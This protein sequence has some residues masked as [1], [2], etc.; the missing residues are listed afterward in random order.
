MPL[1]LQNG[2]K[3]LSNCSIYSLEDLTNKYTKL[4]VTAATCASLSLLVLLLELLAL[5]CLTMRRGC[6]NAVCSWG[7]HV[8]RRGYTFEPQ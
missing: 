8:V 4:Y 6:L 5:G 1:S 3:T 2:R 7:T